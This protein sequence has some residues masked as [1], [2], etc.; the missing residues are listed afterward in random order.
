MHNM[1]HFCP[2]SLVIFSLVSSS[3]YTYYIHI[4]VK[5]PLLQRK[6]ALTWAACY[7]RCSGGSSL[8][9]SK[10]IC[11]LSSAQRWQI[12]RIF[13]GSSQSVTYQV[14]MIKQSYTA[15]M[16]HLKDYKSWQINN[17][18]D[19]FTIFTVKN[20]SFDCKHHINTVWILMHVNAST[21]DWFHLS[22]S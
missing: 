16:C 12:M 4:C 15:G 19:I 21:L 22:V 10:I 17:Q 13:G 2:H 9:V 20:A 3:R 6:L 11:R 7:S 8:I 18:N 5:K 14:Y 1:L